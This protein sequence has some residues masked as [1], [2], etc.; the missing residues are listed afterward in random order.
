VLLVPGVGAPGNESGVGPATFI[1]QF[2]GT[3]EPPLSLTTV[4]TT[5]N[6]VG[7]GPPLAAA[8]KS[9]IQIPAA[10]ARTAGKYVPVVCTV[11]ATDRIMV[12]VTLS[13]EAQASTVF[14]IRRRLK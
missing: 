2:E 12:Q 3:A 9:S 6:V 10:L 5:A 13:G 4:L 1:V 11:S 14:P 8:P 7:W